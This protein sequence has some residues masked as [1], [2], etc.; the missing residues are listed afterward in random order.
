VKQSQTEK[1]SFLLFLHCAMPTR[2][3]ALTTMNATAFNTKE[4]K[5][6]TE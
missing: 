3:N 4:T 2:E 5:K 1:A 6:V